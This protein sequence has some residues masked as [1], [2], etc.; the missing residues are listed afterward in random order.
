MAIPRPLIAPHFVG[1]SPALEAE[2][3]RRDP[4]L[5]AVLAAPGVIGVLMETP[6]IDHDSSNFPLFGPLG[7]ARLVQQG[8]D[9]RATITGAGDLP[10]PQAAALAYALSLFPAMPRALGSLVHKADIVPADDTATVEVLLTQDGLAFWVE[11]AQDHL[12]SWNARVAAGIAPDTDP[13]D[14]RDEAQ[15]AAPLMNF[16]LPT[17]HS[18]HAR[19]ARRDALQRLVQARL[20]VAALEH[21]DTLAL[22]DWD[23]SR[24]TG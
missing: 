3:A 5:Q 15:E 2:L 22:I 24:S 10:V 20:H 18:A 1:S 12:F 7:H 11:D 21:M 4:H 9:G 6:R 8:H 23:L 13:D 19:L 14:L 17:A 16:F